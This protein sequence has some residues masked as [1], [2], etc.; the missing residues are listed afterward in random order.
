[1]NYRGIILCRTVYSSALT[2]LSS[3]GYIRGIIIRVK[4][5]DNLN[6]NENKHPGLVKRKGKI[7]T[8]LNVKQIGHDL[9][10]DALQ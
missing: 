4:C 6:L 10:R 1:M 7:I 8:H 9:A 5:E 2:A 3:I